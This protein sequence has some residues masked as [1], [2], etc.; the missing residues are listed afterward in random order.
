MQNMTFDSE[1]LGAT[2]DFL[3]RAYTPMSI[4]N[5][6]S[7]QAR[8]HIRRDMLGPVS[9][10][11]LD[12]GFD[13]SYDA[14][15]LDKVCL[16]AVQ[17]GN[18]EEKYRDTG[19]DVFT[20]G[21]VGLLT[22]PDLPFSGVCRAP[23]YTITMFDPALLDRV[24]GADAGGPVRFRGHRPVSVAAEHRLAGVIEHLQ[25]IAAGPVSPLVAGTAADYLAATVLETMPTTAVVEDTAQDRRDAHPETVRRAIAYIESHL[26]EDVSVTDI[27]GAAFVTVRA[28]Q[29]AFR[30][31]LDCTPVQYLRRLRLAAAHEDLLAADSV[32]GRTIASIALDWGFNHPGRFAI[33]YRRVYGRAP[34]QALHA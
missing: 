24:G 6:G 3:N 22:P 25:H 32:D 1:D 30:R 15:P 33:A 20:P 7:A 10:D 12:L 28:L 9:L 23:R 14:D 29:L 8:A 4:G 11:R 17:R 5:D 21:Q 34:A 26:R 18:I 31:H 13:M 19:W 16:C 2:E 27:A